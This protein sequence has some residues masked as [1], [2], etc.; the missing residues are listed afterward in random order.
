MPDWKD[1][2]LLTVQQ[3]ASYLQVSQRRLRELIAERRVPTPIKLAGTTRW[4]WRTICE[5]VNAVETLQQLGIDQNADDEN[6]R[7]AAESGDL[8]RFAADDENTDC[9]RPKKR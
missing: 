5:W 1:E 7:N 3:F 6:R 2:D 8:R 9:D 4:R